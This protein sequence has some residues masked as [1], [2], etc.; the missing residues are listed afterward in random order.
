MDD[1]LHEHYGQFTCPECGSHFF[2]TI[3]TITMVRECKGHFRE[4]LGYTEC[5]FTFP[6]EDAHIYGM[7][8]PVE[9]TV[10]FHTSEDGV[11]KIRVNTLDNETGGSV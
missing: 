7:K 6:E 9:G 11:G 10:T 2:R 3:N 8:S 1:I 5:G 4:K